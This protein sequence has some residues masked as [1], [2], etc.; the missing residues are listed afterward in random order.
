MLLPIDVHMGFRWWVVV[1]GGCNKE[2]NWSVLLG[3]SIVLG[4]Q[5]FGFSRFLG[6]LYQVVVEP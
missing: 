4:F 3:I 5:G 1:G 6:V 2:N